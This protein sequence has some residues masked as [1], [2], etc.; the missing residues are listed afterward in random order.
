MKVTWSPIRPSH[1]FNLLYLE[2]EFNHW[3]PGNLCW[4][5]DNSEHH[6][7][8]GRRIVLGLHGTSKKLHDNYK[9]LVIR[10][11]R[12]RSRALVAQLVFTSLNKSE[13]LQISAH[14][15]VLFSL[16]FMLPWPK[17]FLSDK[18]NSSVGR[19]LR[20]ISIWSTHAN[21]NRQIVNKEKG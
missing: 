14:C 2:I 8:K 13:R 18:L 11:F 5:Q 21:E 10:P 17:S 1:T 15:F 16:Y 19:G 20:R 6:N 12:H 4:I 9:C 3:N 7:N